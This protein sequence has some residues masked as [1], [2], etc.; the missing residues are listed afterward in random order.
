MEIIGH[1]SCSW[2]HI[3]SVQRALSRPDCEGQLFQAGKILV[4]GVK[5]VNGQQF[6]IQPYALGYMDGRF[7]E[8]VDEELQNFPCLSMVNAMN[9]ARQQHAF[10]YVSPSLTSNSF[11]LS[12]YQAI[13][14]CRGFFDNAAHW[15]QCVSMSEKSRKVFY[16]TR[17]CDNC[18]EQIN[19][20]LSL[21]LSLSLS[22][23][24]SQVLIRPN[25]SLCVCPTNQTSHST[26]ALRTESVALVECCDV[27]ADRKQ[28]LDEES[29]YQ[30]M[31]IAEECNHTKYLINIIHRLLHVFDGV[32]LVALARIWHKTTSNPKCAKTNVRNDLVVRKD[33]CHPKRNDEKNYQHTKHMSAINVVPLQ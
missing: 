27:E 26:T 7:N 24:Q 29:S 10:K 11:A 14:K 20:C 33:R 17:S 4:F 21:Y 32:T 3:W 30:R 13:L 5:E 19:A 23:S 22:L 31:V 18:S 12:N 28:E 25:Y 9:V 6:A 1:D 16:T 2:I 8:P 15:I